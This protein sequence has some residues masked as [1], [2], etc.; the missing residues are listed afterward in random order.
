MKPDNKPGRIRKTRWFTCLFIWWVVAVFFY[1]FIAAKETN[2]V[3]RVT[4]TGIK[5]VLESAEQAG[6]PLLERDVQAL[7][8]LTQD[9]AT[10]KGVVNVSI[11]DHKNKIIAFT[12]P[13][14]LLSMSS[15]SVQ[16]KDGASYWP[17]T[18]DD[19]IR[20]VCFSTSIIYAGTKIGE[21]FLAMDARG[22]AGLTTAFFLMALVS[23]VLI[24]FV[25]LV[26][27]FHGVHPL[28]AAIRER[29]NTWVGSDRDLPHDREVICPVCGSHKP[30]TRSFL[31]QANLD[32]YPVVRSAR[33]ENE[34][35]QLLLAKGVNLREISRREDLGWLRRQMIHRCAD[36]IKKLAGD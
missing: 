11:I 28:K 7:T 6:L 34:T 18:L 5:T 31:L 27:D 16:L 30:L 3:S 32:R 33:K 1:L 29:I 12:N 17:H 25:L 35:A 9:V 13:D 8:R 22:P 23:F 20:A 15:K 26:L 4:E 14:Q 21:V 2:L 10:V 24:V 19:G 36:I